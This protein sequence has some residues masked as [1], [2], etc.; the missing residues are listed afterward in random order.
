MRKVAMIPARLGSKR[1][2]KKNLRLIDGKPLIAY[3]IE[4]A[5]ASEAFDDIYLNSEA[6]VFGEI[7]SEYGIK[8]YHR[9]ATF[10]SDKSVNDEFALDFMENVEANIVFQ[11]LPTSPLVTGEEIRAFVEGMIEGGYD[12]YVSVVRHQIASLC[13]ENPINFS[14]TEKHRSSQE[15]DPVHSYATVFM[16]WSVKEFKANIERFFGD[17]DARI[18]GSKGS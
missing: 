11:L 10:S 18:L 5:K 4:A 14:R 8:F 6:D 16:G 2:P 7:A 17:F 3:I 1:V 15:M 12:T 9:D 13:G